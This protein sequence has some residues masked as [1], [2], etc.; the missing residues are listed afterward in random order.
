MI[1]TVQDRKRD[2]DAVIWIAKLIDERKIRVRGT[3]R[4]TEKDNT[5]RMGGI[6]KVKQVDTW[7]EEKT[8]VMRE[9]MI[10]ITEREVWMVIEI[11]MTTKGGG[12]LENIDIEVQKVMVMKEEVIVITGREVQIVIEITITTKGGGKSENIDIEVQKLM[13]IVNMIETGRTG[14]TKGDEI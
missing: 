13:V 7:I 12:N 1:E 6:L 3:D 8:E 4:M 5:R 14:M 2:M 11:T 10:M 9:E